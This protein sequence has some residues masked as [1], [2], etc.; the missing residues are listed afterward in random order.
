MPEGQK[1]GAAYV[2]VK[3]EDKTEEGGQRI[4][5]KL[6]AGLG[7]LG[8]GGIISK[9]VT[10]GLDISAGQSKLNAQLG[11][12][13]TQ[14]GVMGHAAGQ[15]FSGGYGTGMDQIQEALKSVELNV[16]GMRGASTAALTDIGG[17]AL[18]TANIFD[19]DLGGVTR[20]VGQLMKT[21]LAKDST[22]AMDIVTAGFQ[23][24]ADKSGDFL[25]TLNE[26]GV[27]FHKMGLNGEQA[28]GII[29]QG[30]KAGARDGD[31]VADAIKEFSIRA[32]DGSTTT[33]AGFKLMGMNGKTMGAAIA[34][35]GDFANE[36]LVNT[37]D[38]LRA[39][40]DPLKRSQAAAALFG[41]QAEDLGQALYAI[42]P[43]TAAKGLGKIKGA[44][45]A[46]GKSF[47]DNARSSMST[48]FRQLQGGATNIIGGL[49]VPSLTRAAGLLSNGLGPAW[50]IAT[51]YAGAHTTQMHI[52][53]GVLGTVAGVLGAVK[54]ATMVA[55]GAT[56]AWGLTTQLWTGITKVATGVQWLFN[57]AMSA[58]PVML[59]VIGIAALT[60][61]VIIAYHKV[62]WFREGV[63]AAF[64]GIR[65]GL[66]FVMDSWRLF[67]T[68]LTGPLVVAFRSV[69]GGFGTVKIM[70]LQAIRV[71]VD[72]FLGMVSTII[73]GAANAFGWVPGLGGKLRSAAVA[74]DGFRANANASLSA[75]IKNVTIGAD[76]RP[77]QQAISGIITQAGNQT[78]YIHV[79][80]V[81]PSGPSGGRAA[82]AKGGFPDNG[83]FTVGEEGPELMRKSGSRLEVLSNRQ[84]HKLVEAR[85]AAE[86]TVKGVAGVSIGELHIA[87]H[88]DD[89]RKA[90]DVFDL[91]TD[92][93]RV[94]GT[95][96]N[97]EAL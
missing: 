93:A 19:Q 77:A 35:G 17:K 70:G 75:M 79:M 1:I 18:N 80:T 59:V 66:G 37:L 8:L 71:L 56:R 55:S 32:V 97:R 68:L 83:V 38:R 87:V 36:A 67:T 52:V 91:I 57:A 44:A 5:A 61:G 85:R 2:E 26:Y 7:A 48:F 50:N 78:A 82:F 86:T 13:K 72:G 65:S 6:T 81:G 84:S 74:I 64:R 69:V 49:V 43:E 89:L 92:A 21:G 88:A 14:S 33:A 29:S 63:Q 9:S 11:L 23:H 27:Q 58:N 76:V 94:A 16:G 31:L 15:L 90:A 24:G 3:A 51:G 95:G 62:G 96:T 4:G 39:M 45:D 28:T 46:A 42:H 73:H 20:A 40:P 60:A 10:S 41:T 22:E 25:D 54:V 34:K 30:L 12:T 53:V 47:N